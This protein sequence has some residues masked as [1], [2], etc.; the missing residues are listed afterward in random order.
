M[1]FIPL[2]LLRQDLKKRWSYA[3]SKKKRRSHSGSGGG[4]M[5]RRVSFP[6]QTTTHEQEPDYGMLADADGGFGADYLDADISAQDLGHSY[7][8]SHEPDRRHDRP[9]S[10]GDQYAD[11]SPYA[12]DA[13]DPLSERDLEASAAARDKHYQATQEWKPMFF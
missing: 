5:D 2:F 10:I 9:P 13:L 6:E 11:Y 1:A 4:K 7:G 3:V 12:D 8:H